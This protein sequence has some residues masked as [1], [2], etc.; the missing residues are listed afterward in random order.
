MGISSATI[1]LNQTKIQSMYNTPNLALLSS[2]PGNGIVVHRASFVYNYTDST[3]FSDGGPLILQ[4]GNSA[5]GL[6]KN[7]LMSFCPNDFMNNSVSCLYNLN[8]IDEEI[9]T[10][11]SGQSLYIS[12]Q[13]QAFSGGGIN[14]TLAVNIWYSI[15]LTNA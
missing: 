9:L 3:A 4:Y 14:A 12:N 13:T 11:I 5:F 15:I 2:G 8:C 7:A 10:G 6:G 1:T